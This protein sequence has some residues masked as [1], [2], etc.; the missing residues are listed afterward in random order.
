MNLYRCCILTSLAVL[1]VRGGGPD[2]GPGKDPFLQ[3]LPTVEAA[4][5]HA[6]TLDEAPANVTLV[7]K[8][9]IRTYGYRT[10]GEALA[11]VRG[12][13]LSSDHIYS[14]AGVRGF[15]LPGDF[16]TRFLVM[17]N[18]HPMTDNVYSSNGFFGQDF[19]LDL[20]LV[21][22]IEVV[23]G[24]SS[25][26][27]GSNGIFATI[28]IV[29]ESPV[30]SSTAYGSIEAG[31]F[32]EKKV[33]AAG[34]YYLGKG[35]NLL[36]SAS[37]INS[38]G[39]SF[40]FPEFD[41]PETG[42][43]RAIHMDGERARHSFAN[44]VWRGW[45]FTAYFNDRIKNVPLAWDNPSNSFFS[46]GNHTEDSRNF[47]SAAYTRALG[48]GNLRW[49]LSYDNYHYA[50]RFDLI[51]DQG[52][53]TRHTHDDGDWLSSQLTYQFPA[54]VL[55]ALTAGLEAGVDLRN[56]QYDLAILPEP[57]EVL[58]IDRPERSGAVFLQQEKRLSPHWKIDLGVRLDESRFYG[59]FVSPRLA[60]AYQPS[61]R[62]VFKFIYGRPFRNPNAYE[63]FYHDDVAFLQAP[64]LNPE[65]ANTF[66]VSVEHHFKSGLS[67]TLNVY[68]YRLRNL[69]Q[70]VYFEN[71]ASQFSNVAGSRSRGVEVELGGKPRPWL[72]T[73]GSFAWQEARQQ[74]AAQRFAN[75][76]AQIAKARAA[77]PL[78]RRVTFASS[79]QWMSSRGT[80]N[81]EQVRPV[82]LADATL[83]VRRFLPECDLQLGVRNA[84]NWAYQDPVALSLDRF[85]GDPRSLYL[86]LIWSSSK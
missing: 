54:G 56:Q 77:V 22:R 64:P 33:M 48:E 81:G 62:T 59:H 16:N 13:Y 39:Q 60:L 10:L 78:G 67:A 70:A 51:P 49:Q 58:H 38:E 5:L 36:V 66:E 68:D 43:G 23:R 6:Q 50:D 21:K 11:S 17:I 20:D 45:S 69:I 57:V 47:V 84:L 72:E 52:A 3:D 29:T 8:A 12:F 71:G 79:L 4:A 34:S 2:P 75:S 31:S 19:G 26:L 82:L 14:Y 42:F 44:L 41:V 80:Y 40:Y 27:Y 37:L 7:T 15:S 35:A 25:A 18:G 74:D 86:K 83:T 32:G 61:P 24:P 73:S 9:D 63:Q 30:G 55:G 85:R 46:R 76:P 28:N 1:T 53:I 65:A